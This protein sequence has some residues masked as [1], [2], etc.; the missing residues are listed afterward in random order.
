M[1]V[2]YQ[3]SILWR[4]EDPAKK[5]FKPANDGAKRVTRYFPGKAPHWAQEPK[6]SEKPLQK[7]S[8]KESAKD[9]ERS[10]RDDRRLKR[11]QAELEDAAS[12]RLRR[13]QASTAHI[14]VERHERHRTIQEVRFLQAADEEESVKKEEVEEVKAPAAE[15]APPVGADSDD[16]EAQMIRRERLRE[17]ALLRRKEEEEKVFLKQEN[18]DSDEDLEEEASE[19][20]SDSEED[21]RRHM[22]LKPVFVSKT[23]RETLKEREMIE[24]EAERAKEKTKERLLERKAESKVILVDTIKQA[25]VERDVNDA[26]DIELID[27]NDEINEAEE[28]D[29]WKIRELKRIK[30]NRDEAST[31]IK[32][33]EWIEKRRN[34]TDEER[35]EDDLKLDASAK[36]REET[37]EFGFMQKYYHRGGFFQDKAVSGEEPLYLRDYHQP[38]AEEKYDKNLLPQAMQLR[39]G[40]F[41]KKGQV[42]HTHLTDV[43]TTDPTAWSQG[44]QLQR[45]QARMATA[46]GVTEFSRPSKAS[47]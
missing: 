37:K 1:S 30:R 28:Y 19:Y 4:G 2:E 27:D 24:Q 31:R 17:R 29:L 13:L 26:S 39:R 10:E 5:K 11:K 3:H 8:G 23:Q 43:D 46:K 15:L 7:V 14:G 21:V 35:A 45:Y 36:F 44:K 42:K 6:E 18:E 33:L 38:L 32:E 12:S 40:Q 25:D 47:E 34:M 9:T 41:G 16:E 22:M 20:E